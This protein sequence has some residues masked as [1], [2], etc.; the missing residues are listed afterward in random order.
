[1][2]KPVTGLTEMLTD[3]LSQQVA[4]HLEAPDEFVCASVRTDPV[5]ECCAMVSAYWE[6]NDGKD[7]YW[8]DGF[9]CCLDLELDAVLP[10]L[11]RK[12]AERLYDEKMS[13]GEQADGTS[14]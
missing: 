12:I 4:Q 2:P 8:W 9:I 5:N 14:R 11:A 13:G 3:D 10:Y 1:M 6:T 7:E